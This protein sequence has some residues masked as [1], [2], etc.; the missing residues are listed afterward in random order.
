MLTSNNSGNPECTC[1]E[2]VKI[3]RVIL[4]NTSIPIFVVKF[5]E[6]YGSYCARDERN[7]VTMVI[8]VNYGL[9]NLLSPNNYCLKSKSLM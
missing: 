1:S 5:K 2:E 7:S 6:Q 3:D 4:F 9:N 8:I